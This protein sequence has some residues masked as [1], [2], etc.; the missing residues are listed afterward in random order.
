MEDGTLNIPQ[1]FIPEEQANI[2]VPEG[3]VPDDS[4]DPI[5][6]ASELANLGLTGMQGYTFGYGPK[7]MSAIGAGMAKLPLEAGEAVNNAFGGDYEA[8]SYGELYKIGV[9]SVQDNVQQSYE[10]HPIL[11]PVAETAGGIKAGLSVG[12]S[13]FGKRVSNWANGSRPPRGA[14]L[15]R[16]M[17]LLGKSAKGALL[18]EAGYRAYKVGTARP[19]E[20]GQEFMSGPPIGGMVGGAIPVM[21]SAI[22]VGVGAALPK[23]DDGLRETAKLA[24]KYN[25]PLSFDE[26]TDSRAIKN[27]QKIS[28]DLPFS[29]QDNFRD[30]QQK[31]F[32][33]AVTK[34]FGQEAD[35]I[36]PELMN[37][38][39]KDLGKQFDDLTSGKSFAAGESYKKMTKELL[40]EAEAYSSSTQDALKKQLSIIEKNISDGSITGEKL[41]FLRNRISKLA[42]K[43]KDPELGSAYKDIE[44]MIIDMA[45][46][47]DILKKAG[48]GETKRQYKNL[49]AVEGIARPGKAKGG[50]IN[51]SQLAAQVSKIYGRNFTRGNAGELG[52]LARIGSDLLPEL[53]GSDTMSKAALLGVS[54]GGLGVNAPVVGATLGANRAT[55]SFINRNQKLIDKVLEE[56]TLSLPPPKTTGLAIGSTSNTSQKIK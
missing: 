31:A 55:Q 11:S 8:P 4:F 52:D 25:I 30:L 5:G 38:A 47:D 3:F 46:E 13:A 56:G 16:A 22:G 32:N 36:T 41:G 2:E 27:L 1:G 44:N 24:R 53:G 26:I 33:K 20:E 19:G 15:E 28:Q 14:L 54:A 49:L 45:T 43:A 39:F 51:P 34:S 9:N 23:V 7:L 12:K 29:G 6:G 17:G 21:G 35:R 40:D 48:F 37:K 50:N 42:Q 10:D 18:G